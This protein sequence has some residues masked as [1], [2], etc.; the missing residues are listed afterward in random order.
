VNK[1]GWTFYQHE[2]VGR[3]LVYRICRRL[4]FSKKDTEYLATL[5]RW[6]QQPISLMDD[7]ITD[8][9]VRRLIVSLE[10]ELDDLL[11]LGVS[12]IT[13]GNPDKLKKRQQNYDKLR[14]RVEEVMEKDKLRAFQS[15]VRGD[16]IMATCNLRPGPTV[17]DIKSD[18]EDAILD[19]KIPN[20][21]EAAKEY[22]ISIKDQ[23][24]DKAEE[25][26]K[27]D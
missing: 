13:T 25:W 15:P 5:V 11:T 19:G 24:I 27:V 17:G 26:E 7:G 21:Y 1:I 14:K 9:A 18:I 12:D 23:Y 20:E 6:H 4:R 3:K 2:H 16:E 22:F 8:S 10:D